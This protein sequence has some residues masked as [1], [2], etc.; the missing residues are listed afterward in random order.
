MR[1]NPPEHG[2][3][4]ARG[5]VLITAA[6]ALLVPDVMRGQSPW[7]Y[8]HDLRL[9]YEFDDNVQE[10]LDDPVRAQVAKLGYHGDILWGGGEQRLTISY[11]G[12]FK[13]HFGLIQRELDVPSQFV[14]EGTV[15]YLRKLTPRLALG[16]Q[17][18]LKHRAWMDGFFF[19]N[20]DGFTRRSGGLNAILDLEPATPEESA[21]IEVGVEWT[22]SKFKNLDR[23]FGSYGLGG[24]GKLT[25]QFGDDIEGSAS[26][27]FDRVRYPGRKA[28][29]PG[30]LTLNILTPFGERQED[31]LHELGA[32]LRWFGP[33]S[34]V[35]DY[36]FRYNDSNSFGFSYV[37]HNLGIQLLRPLPWGMLAH[38]VGQV[39][40]RTFL[41]P[42][43]SV[44]AGS[45]DT[46]DAQNN[47][48]LLRLV[49][50]ITQ[51]YSIEARY[52][53]YRNEAITLNDFYTKNIW[54]LGV[55]Y[56][57]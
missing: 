17:L 34:V 52:A 23:P 11:Q 37:S 19:I 39:E 15:A 10:Q 14:N 40:L 29:E 20:E 31:N 50:D 47:V 16:G 44:T 35:G 45:L 25:K 8:D 38:V 18:G 56:R 30:D 32:A 54:A 27:A 22:D 13:R 7:R 1:R 4:G 6:I 33:V 55:S 49:K 42:V 57:P 53:R 28:L 43:P 9:S 21:Q 3:R 2:R 46:D 24:F 36:R 48:L 12:G 51:D 26:Y 5:V 41:E